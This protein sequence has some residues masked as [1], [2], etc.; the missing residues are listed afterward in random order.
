MDR[1]D[2]QHLQRF[3]CDNDVYSCERCLIKVNGKYVRPCHYLAQCT[4]P[5][6]NGYAHVD[7]KFF[8]TLKNNKIFLDKCIIKKPFTY[9]KLRKYFGRATLV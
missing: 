6:E 9:A 4:S 3:I 5:I 2:Y 1:I 7:S 8:S